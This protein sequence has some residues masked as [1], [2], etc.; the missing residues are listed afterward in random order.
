MSQLAAQGTDE[1]QLRASTTR[2]ISVCSQRWHTPRLCSWSWHSS[3]RRTRQISP[4]LLWRRFL[5]SGCCTDG[6]RSIH[7]PSSLV[8][9]LACLWGSPLWSLM[10][11]GLGGCLI[12]AK[13]SNGRRFSRPWSSSSSYLLQISGMPVAVHTYCCPPQSINKTPLNYSNGTLPPS[14]DHLWQFSFRTRV[15]A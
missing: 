11:C 15:I 5:F 4:H 13:L 8:V 12:R 14:T 7:P 9:M 10:R 3:A 1:P 2:A 6:E